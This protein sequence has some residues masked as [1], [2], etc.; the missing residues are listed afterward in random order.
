MNQQKVVIPLKRFILLEE[1]PEFWKGFDLYLFRDENIVFYVGQSQQAF[2]RVW[3]HLKG[4]FKGHSLVGRF[5]WNNWPASMKFVIELMSSR[6]EQFSDF[7]NDLNA[8]ERHLIECC[9]PCFNISLN[10]QPRPIPIY[11]LPPNA[12]PRFRRSLHRMMYEAARVVQAEETRELLEEE[13]SGID[14][15]PNRLRNT[16]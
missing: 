3:E 1:C 8:A 14:D 13:A 10:S 5:M 6:S 7:A 12:K 11:Y 2:A 9:S 16:R 15:T 4:G